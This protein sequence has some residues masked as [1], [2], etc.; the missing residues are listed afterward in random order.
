MQYTYK[1]EV[2]LFDKTY[3]A[4][5]ILG[6]ICTAAALFF[7]AAGQVIGFLVFLPWGLLAI[8]GLRGGLKDYH[9]WKE[10]RADRMKNGIRCNGKVVDAGG[11]RYWKQ[12]WDGDYDEN[13]GQDTYS[14][15]ESDWWI[16]VEYTDLADGSKK[17]FKAQN[18]NRNGKSLIGRHADVY[19]HGNF[20]YI[21]IPENR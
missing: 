3:K 16:E 8:S 13:G 5:V 18:M 17:R 19:L 15:I 9:K 14:S 2:F 7:L 1:R 20:V 12:H 6:G 21:D 11:H 10:Y 4:K